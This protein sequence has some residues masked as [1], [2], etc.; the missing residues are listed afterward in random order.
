MHSKYDNMNKNGMFY[1]L[2]VHDNQVIISI[3]FILVL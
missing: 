2:N 1:P 3:I